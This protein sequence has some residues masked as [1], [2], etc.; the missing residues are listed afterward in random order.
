[1]LRLSLY[2]LY[3]IVAYTMYSTFFHG[4]VTII[5]RNIDLA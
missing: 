4:D 5:S 1:M 2:I 3:N